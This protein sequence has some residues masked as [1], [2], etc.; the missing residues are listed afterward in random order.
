MLINY[1]NFS[2]FLA[3]VQVY[4]IRNG[5]DAAWLFSIQYIEDLA[6]VTVLFDLR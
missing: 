3:I 6:K 2:L 5:T 4:C 1:G